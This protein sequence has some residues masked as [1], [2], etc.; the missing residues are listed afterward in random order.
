[1]AA[2]LDEECLLQSQAV[3]KDSAAASLDLPDCTDLKAGW[4][5]GIVKNFPL[6]LQ[7]GTLC[8]S[9]PGGLESTWVFLNITPI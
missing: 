8:T 4:H 9:T 5:F 3:T 6:L 7:K 2:A 1:M